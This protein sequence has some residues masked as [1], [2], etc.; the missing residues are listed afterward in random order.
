MH[1]IEYAVDPSIPIPDNLVTRF[2]HQPGLHDIGGNNLDHLKRGQ[3]NLAGW[4]ETRAAA[5]LEVSDEH[6]ELGLEFIRGLRKNPAKPGVKRDGNTDLESCFGCTYALG[7]RRRDQTLIVG[8]CMLKEALGFTT[9]VE[10]LTV[11]DPVYTNDVCSL[12]LED[13]AQNRVGYEAHAELLVEAIDFMRSISRGYPDTPNKVILV[14]Y[15]AGSTHFRIGDSVVYLDGETLK[16]ATVIRS[17]LEP[18]DIFSAAPI[19]QLD[20]VNKLFSPWSPLILR[21]TELEALK[22]DTEFF[23]VF[24][25][26]LPEHRSTP[27]QIQKMKTALRRA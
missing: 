23:E 24:R 12:P 16:K 8:Y 1:A 26:L 17:C 4:I 20:G 25:K 9:T 6:D 3:S 15:R 2:Y 21:E 11:P 10:G 7:E 18:G 5:L 14:D 27:D 19:V 22:R 13:L